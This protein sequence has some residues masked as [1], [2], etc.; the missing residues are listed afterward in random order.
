MFL[1]KKVHI[2]KPDSPQ[3]QRAR[4]E[5]RQKIHSTERAV[6]ELMFDNDTFSICYVH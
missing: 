6:V 4:L 1:S 2:N 3:V 5:A